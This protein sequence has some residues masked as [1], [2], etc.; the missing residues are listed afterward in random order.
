MDRFGGAGAILINFV[1]C[2]AVDARVTRALVFLDDIGVVD[3]VIVFDW[4]NETVAM[5]VDGGDGDDFFNGIDDIRSNSA[6][7]SWIAFS[8]CEFNFRLLKINKNSKQLIE[9]I[10]I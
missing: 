2:W 7:A 1:R 9:F 4:G 10:F 5:V 8:N 3:T 6:I